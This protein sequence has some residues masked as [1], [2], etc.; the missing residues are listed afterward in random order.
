MTL[1]FF[2]LWASVPVDDDVWE[3]HRGNLLR[4]LERGDHYSASTTLGWMERRDATRFEAEGFAHARALLARQDRNWATNLRLNQE[5]GD[6]SAPALLEMAESNAALGRYQEALKLLA[7][8]KAAWGG[9]LGPPRRQLQAT[10]YLA[11]GRESDAI[12]ALRKLTG[13]RVPAEYR[14]PAYQTLTQLYYQQ[15]DRRKARSL[16]E[17]I[18]KNYPAGDVAAA[19]VDMQFRYE[20]EAYLRRIDTVSRHANVYY[21]NRDFDRANGLFDFLVET[22]RDKKI[23]DR[24]RYYRALTHSKQGNTPAAVAAF[25]DEMAALEE[26]SFAGMAAFQYARQMFLDGRDQEAVD[27]ILRFQET[28]DSTKW[29]RETMRLLILTYRRSGDSYAFKRLGLQ[30]DRK[31]TPAWLKQYYHRNGVIWALSEGRLVDA[32]NHL[33]A[34]SKAR[35]DHNEKQEAGVW[36]GMIQWERGAQEAAVDSWLDVLDRDPNHYFGIA[37][38]ELIRRHAPLTN[39]WQ[40]RR[41]RVTNL[42]RLKTEQLRRLYHLA[43]NDQARRPIVT[44]LQ[45][46]FDAGVQGLDVQ[47][48]NRDAQRLADVGRFDRA[49]LAL[50]KRKGQSRAFH[51]NKAIWHGKEGNLHASISHGEILLNSYPRWVPYELLPERVQELSF[52]KG[53]ASIV[54]EKAGQF[55]V[56][57]FLLLAIMR[58][59]S[60]FNHNA[61]SWA[62]A[63]GLMQF[64]PSTAQEMASRVEE[65]D[66]F[67]MPMLYEPETAI[68]LG[69]KYVDH[70][71]ETF[72]DVPLY[73][74]AAYNAGENAVTRWKDFAQQDN[75]LAFVWDVTYTETKY[76]CQKVLRAYH[77]YS[78]VYGDPNPGVIVTPDLSTPGASIFDRTA[79]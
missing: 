29:K 43:P 20:D 25:A 54:Q 21:R 18:Q 24:A 9:A 41:Q 79:D 39:L 75:S 5:I 34:Y 33:R 42:D 15:G 3:W 1:L 11:L 64:I 10:C 49:A 58:E 73:T 14:L 72:N 62:S 23:A 55:G 8:K 48:S 59:E 77:H 28:T 65:L 40:Q 71:M 57:P 78:R 74:V 67:E 4:H 16:T 68:T 27:Y 60:R 44:A 52:P 61:Q 30:I 31:S 13:R 22:A 7:T 46:R 12:T 19:L 26:G 50:R 36:R 6:R 32:D 70:L 37:A 76:Y 51:Y 47:T 53:F 69:A 56:D 17:R 45:S 63:R 38:S 66:D 2:L 35:L